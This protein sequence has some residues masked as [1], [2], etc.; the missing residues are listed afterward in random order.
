[1]AI[2]IIT[3]LTLLGTDLSNM[4]NQISNTL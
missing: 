3:D 2:I 4:F 1:V